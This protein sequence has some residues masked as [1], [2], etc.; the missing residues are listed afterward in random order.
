MKLQ[1]KNKAKAEI[2]LIPL[3]DTIF[4]LIIFFIV[5]ML[6]MNENKGIPIKLPMAKSSTQS[7]KK[8]Y[9]TLTLTKND[10][11]YFNDQKISE[12][13]LN[14][15]L[16]EIKNNNPNEKILLKAHKKISYE[17]VIHLFDLIRKNG[18]QK[19]ILETQYADS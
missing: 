5:A 17:K 1:L 16:Q 2:N 11:I 7:L 15:K 9:T 13:D 8:E 18:L 14:K 10:E 6:R 4:L 19:I 12:S 3:L